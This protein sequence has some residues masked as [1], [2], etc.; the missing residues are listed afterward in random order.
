MKKISVMGLTN[1]ETTINIENFPVEY[2]PV[3]YSFDK[4]SSSVSG[5]GVNVARALKKLGSQVNLMTV[6]G[7]DISGSTALS[8][9]KKWELDTDFIAFSEY[10]TAQSVIMYD[11]FGN[12]RINVDLKN[13]QEFD[14][15][16]HIFERCIID[17]K[18]VVL[19]NINFS[20]KFLSKLNK[21]KL[22][23]TDVHNISD[24]EDNYN[25][26]YIKY[27]DIL[28]QSHENLP[29]SPENWINMLWSRYETGIVVVA[30]G[31]KWCCSR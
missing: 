12:R 23:A 17:S 30:C 19:C 10:E 31:K 8:E 5:V 4:I 20:R 14:F 2:Y 26:D 24:I 15:P 6:L 29:C 1:I 18:I 13:M 16:E 22:I 9:F 11:N 27:A 25:K 3:H 21:D 7:N 28:F